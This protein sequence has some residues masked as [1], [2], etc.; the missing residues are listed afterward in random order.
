MDNGGFCPSQKDHDFSPEY[1]P[2][3]TTATTSF[4][5]LQCIPPSSPSNHASIHSTSM[6]GWCTVISSLQ[7]IQEETLRKLSEQ[8]EDLLQ[9]FAEHKEHG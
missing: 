5:K 7:V 4:H 3:H 1:P 8:E 6:H 9:P 2:Y